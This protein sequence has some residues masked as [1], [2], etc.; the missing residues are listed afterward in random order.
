MALHRWTTTT[1]DD[2]CSSQGSSSDVT[3]SAACSTH[4]STTHLLAIAG[5][6]KFRSL[7]SVAESKPNKYLSA[8]NRCRHRHRLNTVPTPPRPPSSLWTSSRHHRMHPRLDIKFIAVRA[9]D[10]HSKSPHGSSHSTDKRPPK[11][12]VNPPIPSVPCSHSPAF[13]CL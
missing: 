13:H 7:T 2:E 12:R 11:V 10:K 1:S 3:V 8:L 4:A 6:F 9:I 5:W